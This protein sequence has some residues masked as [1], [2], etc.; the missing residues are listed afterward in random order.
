MEERQKVACVFVEA[1]YDFS[2]TNEAI[3]TRKQGLLIQLSLV[4]SYTMMIA[5]EENT[6]GQS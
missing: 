1:L 4:G 5:G 6:F 2:K 3:W